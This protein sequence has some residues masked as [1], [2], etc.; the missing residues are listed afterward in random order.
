VKFPY[1]ERYQ[2][3]NRVQSSC[4]LTNGIG[5]T[6]INASEMKSEMECEYPTMNVS[7]HFAARFSGLVKSVCTSFLHMKM[8]AK[9]YDSD[10][11]LINVI[12][13]MKKILRT[14]L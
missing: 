3:C 13:T 11:A 1:L 7:T 4:G 10:H 5:M 9:I 6:S 14:S 8:N 2:Y 12:M